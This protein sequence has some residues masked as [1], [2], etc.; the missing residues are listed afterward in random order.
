MSG[1][2][3]PDRRNLKEYGVVFQFEN[4]AAS[5]RPSWPEAGCD[6]KISRSNLS[7]ADGWCVITNI[8]SLN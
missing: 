6:S 2:S 1:A 3:E 8:D 5:D 7:G 4:V